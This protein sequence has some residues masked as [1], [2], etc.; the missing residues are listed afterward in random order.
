MFILL[1]DKDG[2]RT[3]VNSDYIVAIRELADGGATISVKN[4]DDIVSLPNTNTFQGIFDT[5]IKK[6]GRM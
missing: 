1:L 6:E 3:L 2:N 4:P 5:I